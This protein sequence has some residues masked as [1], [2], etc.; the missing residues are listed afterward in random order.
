M[1]PIT[2]RE[3]LSLPLA[4]AIV[5]EPPAV[6]VADEDKE[7]EKKHDPKTVEELIAAYT[8]MFEE[9]KRLRA[10]YYYLSRTSPPVGTIVEYASATAPECW[11]L[12]DGSPLDTEKRPDYKQLAEILG[13]T[14]DP[15]NKVVKLPDLRGRTPVG[16]GPGPSL[17]VRKLG[18]SAGEET[19]TLVVT[20]LP[21][22]S[23]GVKD[24]G[25]T[26]TLKYGRSFH[27]TKDGGWGV[28]RFDAG[29]GDKGAS[30]SIQKGTTGITIENT[31]DNRA[32]NNMQPFTVVNFIIKYK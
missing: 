17:S 26:H 6:H 32:H 9:L 27:P 7:A 31:G 13:T 18:V 2:R 25:H 8:D 3:L 24:D 11:L 23:H 30:E 21:S 10:A 4:S 14:F 29:F 12:C 15:A 22:H 16:A 19:H 20:E 1:M 28:P 5:A